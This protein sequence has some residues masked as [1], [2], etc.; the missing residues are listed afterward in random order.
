MV[1]QTL[2]QQKKLNTEDIIKILKEKLSLFDDFISIE[3]QNNIINI[4]WFN[5]KD[6]LENQIKEQEILK[7]FL[8]FETFILIWDKIRNWSVEDE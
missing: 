3:E 4:C 7:D 5:N 1:I 8:D 6:S 2:Q